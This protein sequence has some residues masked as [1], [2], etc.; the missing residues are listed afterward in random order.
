MRRRL[1]DI[2]LVS[3]TPVTCLH[4]SSAGDP[5]AYLIRGAVVAIRSDDSQ[6]IKIK[7]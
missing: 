6:L 1:Q 3:G 5:A 4:V 7:Q 2:G